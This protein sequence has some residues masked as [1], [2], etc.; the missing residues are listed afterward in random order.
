VELQKTTEKSFSFTI[1]N[2]NVLV[3]SLVNGKKEYYCR[4]DWKTGRISYN[5]VVGQKRLSSN[6]KKP[7]NGVLKKIFKKP[8]KSGLKK[9]KKAPKKEKSL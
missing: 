1:N 9:L 7:Q 4:I 5:K 6:N 3:Y 8:K 2:E